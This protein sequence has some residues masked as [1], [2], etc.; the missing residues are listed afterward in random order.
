MTLL[1]MVSEAALIVFMSVILQEVMI[2]IL[3]YKMSP[4]LLEQL[5]LHLALQ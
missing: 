4:F 2:M 5:I 1:Q 3:Y